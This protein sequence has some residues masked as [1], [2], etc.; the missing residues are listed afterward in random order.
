MISKK[1]SMTCTICED[2]PRCVVTYPCTHCVM[3]EKCAGAQNECPFCHQAITQRSTIFI[4]VWLMNDEMEETT[5]LTHSILKL[6]CTCVCIWWNCWFLVGKVFFDTAKPQHQW[7][8]ITWSLIFSRME[9][10]SHKV[11]DFLKWFHLFVFCIFILVECLVTGWLVGLMVWWMIFQ[12]FWWEMPPLLSPFMSSKNKM[13]WNMVFLQLDDNKFAYY[14]LLHRCITF[15][16]LGW[17]TF[18]PL[19]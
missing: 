13:L 8:N 4:P 12:S 17:F 7:W 9:I 18:F 11:S 16:L 15:P 1:E 5:T 2:T 6:V 10:W 19:Q 14:Y 3:C